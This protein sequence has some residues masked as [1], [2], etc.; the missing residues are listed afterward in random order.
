M[1]EQN[2]RMNHPKH[3]IHLHLKP[4]NNNTT[5][6]PVHEIFSLISKSLPVFKTGSGR[7]RLSIVKDT[8]DR[9]FKI[10]FA[11]YEKRSTESITD[12]EH[13]WRTNIDWFDTGRLFYT[14]QKCKIKQ[15]PDYGIH[16]YIYFLEEHEFESIIQ[17]PKYFVAVNHN[18][19]KSI[20]TKN[21]LF[22]IMD[23]KTYYVESEQEALYVKDRD[24]VDFKN[25]SIVRAGGKIYEVVNEVNLEKIDLNEYNGLFV[26]RHKNDIPKSLNCVEIIMSNGEKVYI[27]DKDVGLYA[28]GIYPTK[29]VLEGVFVVA[30]YRSFLGMKRE[31]S[32]ETDVELINKIK[33]DFNNKH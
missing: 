32:Y 7:H 4:I 27:N 33:A 26:F 8:Y 28:E 1:F 15:S 6:F 12:F 14:I 22:K 24:N 3:N 13:L 29:G 16:V 21:T 17:H 25:V 18:L 10:S 31:Y 2:G 23:K 9:L 19:K 11:K 20:V 30:V 5:S